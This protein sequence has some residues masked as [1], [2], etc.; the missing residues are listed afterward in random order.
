MSNNN[1]LNLVDRADVGNVRCEVLFVRAEIKHTAEL[2]LDLLQGFAGLVEF[3]KQLPFSA[4]LQREFW[5]TN[6]ANVLRQI[7][8][9]SAKCFVTFLGKVQ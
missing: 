1:T 6:V 5:E 3:K 9:L 7:C 8:R 2:T 4:I